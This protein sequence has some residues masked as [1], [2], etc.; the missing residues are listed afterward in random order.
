M[1]G[2]LDALNHSGTGALTHH[3]DL[4][5]AADICLFDGRIDVA[6]RDYHCVSPFEIA[7]AKRSG[8]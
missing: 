6:N 5:W 1:S 2:Q 8:C 7:G 3:I 4:Q